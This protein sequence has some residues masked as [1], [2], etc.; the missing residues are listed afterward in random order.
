MSFRGWPP[1]HRG[2]LD[3]TTQRAEL[4]RRVALGRPLHRLRVVNRNDILAGDLFRNRSRR[5]D[6]L[7]HCLAAWGQALVRTFAAGASVPRLD[8]DGHRHPN[9]DRP[10]PSQEPEVGCRDVRRPKT[11]AGDYQDAPP[12]PGQPL[13][14]AVRSAAAPPGMIGRARRKPLVGTTAIAG[15]KPLV[16]MTSQGR[17][18]SEIRLRHVFLLSF[19]C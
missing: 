6:I 16:G 18:Q 3:T 7:R 10:G 4:A 1:R 17:D 8:A 5:V 11:Q 2:G 13:V 12:P 19:P 15:R 9:R 14:G